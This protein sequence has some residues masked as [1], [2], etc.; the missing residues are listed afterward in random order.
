VSEVLIEPRCGC[1]IAASSFF[2]NS[3]CAASF[4]TVFANSNG[5]CA[6]KAAQLPRFLLRWSVQTCQLSGG[7]SAAVHSPV[8]VLTCKAPNGRRAGSA[9]ETAFITQAAQRQVTNK[10]RSLIM[11]L[12]WKTMCLVNVSFATRITLD[13]QA[14]SA[15]KPPPTQPRQA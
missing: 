14:V 1:I 5:Y 4:L 15:Q 11:P 10:I 8:C 13:A 6:E 3:S 7:K 12:N 2:S 9:A